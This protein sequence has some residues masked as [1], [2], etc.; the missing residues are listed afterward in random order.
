MIDIGGFISNSI[1]SVGQRILHWL[2]ESG[3]EVRIE[4]HDGNVHYQRVINPRNPEIR[5]DVREE[6]RANAYE[7]ARTLVRLGAAVGS[8]VIVGTAVAAAGVIL[9]A[10][11]LIGANTSSNS[12]TYEEATFD[13]H[14]STVEYMGDSTNESC[15]VC[16]EHFSEGE[17][18]FILPC[19]HRYH[20]SCIIPWLLQTGQCS[21]CRHRVRDDG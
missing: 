11:E 5:E 8:A 19:L 7:G 1:R 16:L 2:E 3:V 10:P 12:N 17:T 20:R 4:Y 6:P 21:V 15:P 9:A 18:I 13:N 14:C